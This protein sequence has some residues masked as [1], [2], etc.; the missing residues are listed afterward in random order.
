MQSPHREPLTA[1]WPLPGGT[2][3]RDALL[4]DR[5]HQPGPHGSIERQDPALGSSVQKKTLRTE[6]LSTSVLHLQ[7]LGQPT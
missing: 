2:P 4:Q 7:Q 5:P 3:W 1:E 6:S